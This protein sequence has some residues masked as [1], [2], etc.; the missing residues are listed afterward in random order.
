[1]V[2]MKWLGIVLIIL[3]LLVLIIKFLTRNKVDDD[4]FESRMGLMGKLWDECCKKKKGGY[5]I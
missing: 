3:V 4:E 1:M 2:F 5:G